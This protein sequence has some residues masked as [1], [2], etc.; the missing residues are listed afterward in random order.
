MRATIRHL[1]FAVAAMSISF[2]GSDLIAS[3]IVA[4]PIEQFDGWTLIGGGWGGSGQMG[5]NASAGYWYWG[6]SWDRPATVGIEKTFSDLTVTPGLYTLTIETMCPGYSPYYNSVPLAAFSEFGLTGISPTQETALSAPTPQAGVRSWTPWTIRYSV[7]M[8]SPDVGNPLGFEALYR[9]TNNTGYSVM[10]DDLHV[11]FQAVPEPS[12]L[13]LLG[14]GA[15]S[16]LAY[17]WHRR[18]A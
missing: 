1:M 11:S 6:S 16:L 15:F 14:I 5:F 9:H 2:T 4:D 10:L 8:N 18:R 13:A 3:T 7:P 17:A 12:T